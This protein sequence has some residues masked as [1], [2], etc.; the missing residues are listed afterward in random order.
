MQSGQNSLPSIPSILY[1]INHEFG[2][3]I[4]ASPTHDLSVVSGATRSQQRVLRRL[5]T[6]INGYIWHTDYGA[7]IPSYIGQALNEDLFLQIKSLIQSQI[8]L[9]SSVAQNPAPVI[10]LQ[11]I[12][13]GLYC[14]INYYLNPTQ[15]P[16]TLNFNVGF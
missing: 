15:Q 12:S 1:D 4:Q 2:N 14:Q 7:G 16:I 3:D 9:E 10:L 11:T 6:S 5:L 13:N 8:N